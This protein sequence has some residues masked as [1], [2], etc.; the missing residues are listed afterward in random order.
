[1][2]QSCMKRYIGEDEYK[3]EYFGHYCSGNYLF[4]VRE[5]KTS[6]RALKI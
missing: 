1:M 4:A 3:N 5:F 2:H 6:L